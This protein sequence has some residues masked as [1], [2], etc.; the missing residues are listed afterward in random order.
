MV[1]RLFKNISTVIWTH[2]GDEVFSVDFAADGKLE[3]GKGIDP[4]WI[5]EE[6][7]WR[8]LESNFGLILTANKGRYK[9]EVENGREKQW[10]A[11]RIN[12]PNPIEDAGEWRCMVFTGD[13]NGNERLEAE[14]RKK[15][16]VGK[17]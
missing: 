14:S 3:A 13:S 12:Q 11:L 1:P 9:V 6:K 5:V 4:K 17:I 16:E 2:N 10:I 7:V 15:I 8:S